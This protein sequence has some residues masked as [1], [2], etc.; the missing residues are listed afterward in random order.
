MSSAKNRRHLGTRAVLLA[1]VIAC[2]FMPSLAGYTAPAYTAQGV[3]ESEAAGGSRKVGAQA[4]TVTAGG[5]AV[6]AGVAFTTSVAVPVAA[7]SDDAE[8]APA[9]A[10][11]LGSSDLELVTDGSAVQTVGLRFAGVAVPNTATVVGAYVQFQTD[12]IST[13]TAAL[14]IQGQAADNAATFTTSTRNVSSRPRTSAS[15]TWTPAQ[16]NTVEERGLAQRTSDLSSIVQEVVS[17]AGWTS[18]NAL[19][20]VFTGSGRRTAEARDGTAAPVLHIEYELGPRQNRAPTVNAG[21]DQSVILP[22]SISLSGAVNDDGLPDPP[23]T[24]TTAWSQVSGPGTVSFGDP[25]LPSTTA[26]FSSAGTYVLRLTADDSALNA[27]DELTVTVRPEG[28]K[29][30]PGD[31][32]GISP[33]AQGHVG[34]F[35]D[36]NG[37][38]YTV[39]EI[40]AADPRMKMM[41]SSDGG[42]SWVEVDGVNRPAR[43]DLEAVWIVQQGNALYIIHQK[44]GAQVYHHVFNTSDASTNP[45]RWILKDQTVAAP[46]S[47]PEQYVSLVILSNG[48]LWAFY[49]AGSRVGYRKK[50]AGGS[51]GAERILDTVST[52]QVVAVRAA[53]D[54][55]HIFYKDGTNGQIKHRS[56]TP[57]GT[58][59]SAERVDDNGVHSKHSPMTNAVYYDDDGVETVVV[60]W[61]DRVGLL[62]SARV[63][64]DGTPTAEVTLSGAPVL[65]DPDATTNRAAVAHLAIDARKV[66]AVWA[67]SATADIFY[68]TNEDDT[69]WGVDAEIRDAVAAHWLYCSVFTHSAGNGGAK[70][71]GYIYDNSTDNNPDTPDIEYHELSLN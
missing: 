3:Q 36:G 5:A 59:S 49:A 7:S 45:N 47:P 48:D 38:L 29:V 31:I 9:G 51:W 50:P 28:S 8:E 30:L 26:S 46:S 63:L 32:P 4:L 27:S 19:A 71:L 61:A 16:W 25:A 35:R 40:T 33:E 17:R 15:T 54:R 68:D 53:N 11:S 43:N 58:L 69:G 20:L 21:A 41:K 12:E 70:V 60:A 10:V 56:L 37:N 23:A 64:D 44:S 52:G 57:D 14:T 1:V 6:T 42:Q 34:P 65:I 67:D 2:A 66:H 22:A 24:V 55:T 18:G 62:K 39:S 13:D